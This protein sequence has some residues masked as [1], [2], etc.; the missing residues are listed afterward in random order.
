M[1]RGLAVIFLA[2]SLVLLPTL[3]GCIHRR[4]IERVHAGMTVQEVEEVLGE[5]LEVVVFPETATHEYRSYRG[6]GKDIIHVDFE[7]GV[8]K[9]AFENK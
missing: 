3:S 2:T 8:A 9:D 7:E 5:P 1:L 4:K 6:D